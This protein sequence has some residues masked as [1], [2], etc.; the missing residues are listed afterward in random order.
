M[1]S[2]KRIAIFASGSGT[3][4]ETII[5]YFKNHPTIQVYLIFTNKKTA[6][7]T[8]RAS[9][10]NVP[11]IHFNR[12]LLYHTDYINE[13]L[14]LNQIDMIVL[15]GFMWLLPAHII[16][17]F[18][19]R[20]I[21]IHPALLPKYGGKGMYGMKVH[22]TVL[23]NKEK[24]T[25]ISI[26]YVNEEYD[27]GALITQKKCPIEEGDTPETIAQKVH[28]LEYQY[29]PPIIEEICTQQMENKA[30]NK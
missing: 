14:Q 8:E 26:H 30:T 23:Q 1:E 27:Q 4:A 18:E 2:T 5:S 6:Y 21:N 3:N 17:Q 11:V 12:D 9:Y 29:Y 19:K 7:V 15:A 20:I 13:L 10:Q 16:H 22:E 28:Q 25:G 24:E